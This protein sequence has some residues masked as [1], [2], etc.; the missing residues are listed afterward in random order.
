MGDRVKQSSPLRAGGPQAT[1]VF[2]RLDRVSWWSR[3]KKPV[4]RCSSLARLH[5]GRYGSSSRQ[6][7]EAFVGVVDEDPVL[8]LQVGLGLVRHRGGWRRRRRV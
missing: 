3:F 1:G 4:C 5:V 2:G 6:A 8:V 7:F